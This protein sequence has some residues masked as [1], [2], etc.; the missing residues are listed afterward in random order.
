M[1][2]P[3][4][5]RGARLR[6]DLER[7]LGDSAPESA[8][9]RKGGKGVAAQREDDALFA[10][11]MRGSSR[12]DATPGADAVAKR[13]HLVAAQPLESTAAA[14][15]QPPL[16]ASPL[17]RRARKASPAATRRPPA[18]RGPDMSPAPAVRA[19]AAPPTASRAAVTPQHKY[20]QK[21]IDEWT[22]LVELAHGYA[23]KV[24]C[25]PC[26]VMKG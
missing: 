7:Y 26:R 9:A 25:S 12:G 4:S 6:L 14:P 1:A 21:L 5:D 19:V 11:I 3:G 23:D 15:P 10:S 18:L 8:L 22:K 13:Q 24:C 16:A 20:N 2:S 17:A